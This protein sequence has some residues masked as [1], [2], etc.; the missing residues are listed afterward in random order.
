MFFSRFTTDI[1][2]NWLLFHTNTF[3]NVSVLFTSA[4]AEKNKDELNV[5]KNDNFFVKT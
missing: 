1:E 5:S 4:K 2:T 3:V